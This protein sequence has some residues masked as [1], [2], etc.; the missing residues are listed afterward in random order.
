MKTSF[1]ILLFVTFL[2]FCTEVQTEYPTEVKYWCGKPYIPK[3]KFFKNIQQLKRDI[4]QC[5]KQATFDSTSKDSI[6][7]HDTFSPST[8]RLP[9]TREPIPFVPNL[10]N[11]YTATFRN[12]PYL[13][14][15]SIGSLVVTVTNTTSTIV[16]K[17]SLDDGT[18]ILAATRIKIEENA[19][20]V[21]FSL[22][23]IAPK[24]KAYDVKISFYTKD[25]GILVHTTYSKLYHLPTGPKTVKIDRLY[26]GIFTST[27]ETIFPVGPYVD[28]GG[29]L[30]KGNIRANLQTLK[31]LNYNI[32]SPD[33]P[34]PNISFIHQMFQ[35]AD[36]I[37]GIY[38]QYS[39]RHEYTN[40]QKVFD[41]VNQFK[42][43]SSLL[44]WYI[45]D[46][47]DGEQWTNASAVFEAYEVIKRVDPYHPAALVLNCQHSAAFYADSTDILS[48]DVYPVGI[49]TFHSTEYSG[50]CGCDNCVGNFSLD[51]P[52]RTQKYMIDLDLIG[53]GLI[54]KWMVL[55]AFFDQNSWWERAPTF[56][57]IRAMWYISIIYG[58]KGLMFWRFPFILEHSTRDQITNLSKRI[59]DLSDYMLSMLQ[60]SPS[61]IIIS[62]DWN[63]YAGGW[64]SED[65]KTFL[66]IVVNDNKEF[67]INFRITIKDLISLGLLYGVDKTDCGKESQVFIENGIFEGNLKAYEIGIFIFGKMKPIMETCV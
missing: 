46:E 56:Q 47:P 42:N 41:Q 13:S 58:Y 34:Y 66:L 39:F 24:L 3:N 55:Q 33:P 53:R 37:G 8:I 67:F 63:I 9:P 10:S 4:N 65:Q 25:D 27:N 57:E 59:K 28:V 15:D 26:G 36:E 62:P 14:T 5:S 23:N 31:D 52:K 20:E 29:W 60:L 35:A 22:A 38:I 50:V 49:N 45:A 1:N 54:V 12:Q 11:G 2:L 61:H 21:P 7:Y 32:I 19:V 6:G 43:Y 44:T 17:A 18:E 16:V 30:A 40:T 64:I 51:I 48:T